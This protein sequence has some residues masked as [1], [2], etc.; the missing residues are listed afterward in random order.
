MNRRVAGQQL[1]DRQEVSP[2][3]SGTWSAIPDP[4]L[5]QPGGRSAPAATVC[6]MT[7]ARTLGISPDGACNLAGR[8]AFPCNVVDTSEGYRVSIAALLQVLGSGPVRDA[9]RDSGP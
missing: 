2:D 7:A 4:S 9:G 6:L 5:Q 3:D 8:D 1:G